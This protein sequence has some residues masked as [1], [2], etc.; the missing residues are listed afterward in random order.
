MELCLYNA[1]LTAMSADCKQFTYV[2][3]LAS[4]D[5]D[6]SERSESF[7]CFCCPPNI[8][9]LLGMIGGYVWNVSETKTCGITQINVHLYT[10]ATLEIETDIGSASLKQACDWPRHGKVKFSLT[11][12]GMDIQ[13][14]LRI[15]RWATTWEVSNNKSVSGASKLTETPDITAPCCSECCGWVPRCTSHLFGNPSRVHPLLRS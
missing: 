2:N 11:G 14:K 10:A 8:L 4:S 6:L 3:Q 1:V 12:K 13:L 9:R 5:K 7:T 15:P